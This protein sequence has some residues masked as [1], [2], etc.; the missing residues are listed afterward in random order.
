MTSVLRFLLLS[1]VLLS[2]LGIGCGGGSSK[3]TSEPRPTLIQLVP[4]DFLGD[5]PCL[6]A[7]SAA[8]GYVATLFDVTEGLTMVGT[9]GNP[10]NGGNAGFALPSTGFLRCQQPAAFGWVVPGHLYRAEIQGYDRADLEPLGPG[11][12]ILVDPVTR[13]PVPPAWEA[14][15]GATGATGLRAESQITRRMRVCQPFAGAPAELAGVEVRVPHAECERLAVE[16]LVL[17]LGGEPVASGACG[18]VLSVEG[19]EPAGFVELDLLA[20]AADSELAAF[21]TSCTARTQPALSV[22]AQCEPF[23]AE[24]SVAIELADVL[25]ALGA[26]CEVGVTQL[27]LTLSDPSTPPLHLPSAQCRGTTR[28]SALLPGEYTV[29]IRSGQPPLDATCAAT[30]EPGLVAAL[31]CAPR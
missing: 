2:T 17:R 19:L 13:Q 20:F 30:V 29:A 12:P 27:S 26:D 3:A 7:P 16:R 24:G 9:G 28:F 18:D 31:D 6:E 1:G 15:C 23:A 14:S 10:G 5:V 22:Q 21:G 25:A 11:V 8:R 4:E